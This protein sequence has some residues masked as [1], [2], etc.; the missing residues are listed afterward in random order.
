LLKALL[1]PTG[2]GETDQFLSQLIATHAEPVIKG[3]IRHKLHLNSHRGIEQAEADD[4]HQEVVVQLLAAL[5]RLRDPTDRINRSTVQ[6]ATA[7]PSRQSCRQTLR[8]P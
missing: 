1:S 5:Q 4:I 7:T 6:R 2:D 3:I 8:A